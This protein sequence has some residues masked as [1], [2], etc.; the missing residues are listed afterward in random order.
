[1]RAHGARATIEASRE[2]AALFGNG[3]F[4]IPHECAG[5]LPAS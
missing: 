5:G 3:P 1:M 4:T 2:R